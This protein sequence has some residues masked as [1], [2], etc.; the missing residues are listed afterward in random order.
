MSDTT[1]IERRGPGRLPRISLPRVDTGE[2][3][4]WRLPR[5]ARVLVFVPSSSPDAEGYLEA[6]AEHRARFRVWDGRPLIVVPEPPV[7][8]GGPAPGPAVL[9]YPIVTDAE[10]SAR[11]RCGL[12]RDDRAVI[13]AD[14]WGEVYRAWT[15]ESC[16]GLPDAVE[17]EEWVRFI[18]TQCP[19]CG[20]PDEPT[21]AGRE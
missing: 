10:G 17:I 21:P 7:E 20:V 18:T 13:I 11:R 8:G 14:R 3:V 9:P 12:A 15:A 6:L 2:P 5:G 1:D 16:E 4:D 19:E